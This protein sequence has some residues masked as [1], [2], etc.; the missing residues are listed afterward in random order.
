[1]PNSLQGRSLLTGQRIS[2][3]FENGVLP[4]S[5]RSPQVLDILREASAQRTLERWIWLAGSS[6]LLA[7][8]M[9]IGQFNLF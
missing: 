1:M 4:S 5:F 8:A 6:A 3:Q 9:W 7:A 2:V